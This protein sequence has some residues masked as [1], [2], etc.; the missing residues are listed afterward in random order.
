MNGFGDEGERGVGYLVAL[1]QHWLLIALVVVAAVAAAIV[2]SKMAEPRYEAESD[3]LVTPISGEDATFTG[4]PLIRESGESRAVLTVARLIETPP[5][6]GAAKAEL[7]SDLSAPELLESIEVTPQEQSTIVTIVG[8]ASSGSE[9]A[10]IA[11]A[12]ATA[13]VRERTKVFQEALDTVIKR[14]EARVASIP[15]SDRALGEAA[16]I[17]QRIDA[18]SSLA[19]EQDPTLQVATQAVAPTEPVWPKPALSVAVALLAG[20]MLGIGLAIALEIV[21]PR[22]KREDELVLEQRLPILAR[23]PR[24]KRKV[25]HGYLRG[26][27]ALPHDVRE[28]YRMLR[29]TLATAAKEGFPRAILVTSAMP[30]EGKTMTSVNLAISIA[31]TR[32]KVILVDGDMRRPMVGTALGMGARP[33]GLADVLRDRATAEDALVE[34]PGGEKHLRLL[35]SNPEGLSVDDLLRSDRVDRVLEELEELADVIVVDSPALTEVS[36]ALALADAADATL[37]VVRVGRTRRDKLIELRRMLSQR[38]VSPFGFVVT[39][40]MRSRRHGYYRPP[41]RDP[42]DVRKRSDARRRSKVPT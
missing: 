2:Y 20:L 41:E 29:A 40:N 21:G 3:V 17:Q 23:V 22:I 38:K 15:Q 11:N 34:A 19:G 1:R 26:E 9:A 27:Q 12:F 10:R 5:V 14:S 39:T 7:R 35:L 16:G 30:G 32:Q 25:A 8:K 6:A 24:M 31:R 42:L 18:L 37:V 13:L 28:A 36:D 33:V 4:I